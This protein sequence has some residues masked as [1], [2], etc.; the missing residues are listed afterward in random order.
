MTPSRDKVA[1]VSDS[2]DKF[3]CVTRAIEA[4]G[5]AQELE[6]RRSAAGVEPSAFRIV[7]K[8]DLTFFFRPATTMTDPELVEHLVEWL[9]QAGYSNVSLGTSQESS[10]SWLDNRDPL[11]LA[12]LAGYHFQTKNGSYDFCDFS[13]D[14]EP[15]A[16]PQ[17][18][19]LRN[20]S[21]S[22]AWLEAHFRI[23]FA[24]CRTDEA[25]FYAG[26]LQNLL[27]V[28]PLA[29]KEQNYSRRMPA[30]DAIADLLN[31]TPV[32]FALIDAYPANQGN[33]GARHSD[34]LPVS[35]IIAGA[36]PHFADWAV[37]LKLGVDPWRSPIVAK[38]LRHDSPDHPEVIGDLAPFP[39]VRNVHPMVA[40]AVAKR[41]TSPAV[42]RAATAWLQTVDRGLFPFKDSFTDRV[43][44]LLAHQ[45]GSLDSNPGAFATFLALN[46]SLAGANQTS[47]ALNVMFAKDR[48]HWMERPLNLNLRVYSPAD[49][50]MSKTYMEP[51]EK[52]AFDAPPD[53]DGLRWLYLDNSVLF[54]CSRQLPIPFAEFVQR[55]DIARAVRMMNDYIGG[56]CVPVMRDSQGRVTHQAERNLYLPQPNY[57]AFTGGRPIDVSKLEFIA[58]SET[59]HKIFWRALKSENETARFDDGTVAFTNTGESGTLVTITARQ[60]F[61]LPPFWQMLN[62]DLAPAIKDY[63]VSDAYR[64]FFTRTLANFEAAFEGR[65]Y[66]V[67]MEWPDATGGN[68]EEPPLPTT[69]LSEGVQ[70]LAENARV[71]I[72]RITSAVSLSP[73]RP[74]PT[75][76]DEQG[77]AHFESQPKALP[78]PAKPLLDTSLIRDA[79]ATA[80]TFTKDLLQAVSRDLAGTKQKD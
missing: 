11:V 68:A 13:D 3:A 61:I 37:A 18:S 19:V 75:E 8:P 15:A 79:A 34:P 44:L 35:T 29:D 48:V 20:T 10:Q 71:A 41:N 7:I 9:F 24:K 55:V 47:D 73:S 32:H 30:A 63:L 53:K 39:G 5:L 58:Y 36:K 14:L 6:A 38:M 17:G 62:L 4:A 64:N 28:L 50:E 25:F 80:A 70:R 65:E 12:D 60:E 26:A 1:I 74:A 52:I 57:T 56:S 27:G 54:Y 67:G 49:Y 45:F 23:S 22:R 51:L 40:D 33:A 66:R 21:L 77:F 78:E 69:R 2:E 31:L 59:E 46:Y 43:N 42:Q 16:F 76:V 72:D